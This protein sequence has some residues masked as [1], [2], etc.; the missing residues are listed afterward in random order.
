MGENSLRVDQ[1]MF[2]HYKTFCVLY[3]C[4]NAS[5]I[6]CILIPSHWRNLDV[7][8]CCYSGRAVYNCIDYGRPERNGWKIV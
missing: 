1:A 3:G 8:A 5:A 2:E 4:S 7:T 6:D